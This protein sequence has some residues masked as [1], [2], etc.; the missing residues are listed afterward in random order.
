MIGIP[1]PCNTLFHPFVCSWSY[2]AMYFSSV[3]MEFSGT[4]LLFAWLYARHGPRAS[5]Q[6]LIDIQQRR[7]VGW[8]RFP[9]SVNLGRARLYPSRN[10]RRDVGILS[11]EAR[12]NAHCAVRRVLTIC[13]S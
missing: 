12:R 6:H 10:D 8:R 13:S 11:A 3:D 2:C 7:D 1:T 9:G 5:P 4:G